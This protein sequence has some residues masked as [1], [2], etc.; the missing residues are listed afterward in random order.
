M[1]TE[2]AKGV[3]WRHVFGD[4][5]KILHVAMVDL[6]RRPTG[7]PFPHTHLFQHSI[8]LP[9]SGK[10]TLRLIDS[11]LWWG[12]CGCSLLL[13]FAVFGTSSNLD[14]RPNK[15]ASFI[16]LLQHFQPLQILSELHLARSKKNQQRSHEQR[17]SYA[18]PVRSSP[19]SKPPF[20]I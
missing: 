16:L 10:E 20:P 11:P 17:A 15:Q 13:L 5:T 1:A 12:L 6:P 18:T 19:S 14:L 9:G 7:P 3:Y 4:D 8:Q 2:A